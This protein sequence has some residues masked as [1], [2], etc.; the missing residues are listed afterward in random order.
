MADANTA[1]IHDERA[2][3]RSAIAERISRYEDLEKYRLAVVA[4]SAAEV[5][6]CAGGLL[7]DRVMSGWDIT[8]L[9]ADSRD[10]RPLRILGVDVVDLEVAMEWRG[11]QQLCPQGLAVTAD[12]FDSDKRVRA[13][14][15]TTLAVGLTEVIVLGEHCPGPLEHELS[16]A[17]HCLSTAARAFK[18]RALDAAAVTTGEVSRTEHFY[19]NDV[20]RRSP[21]NAYLVRKELS[22]SSM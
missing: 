19:A 4:T 8:V 12:L 20:D 9:V 17:A 7:F 3:V 5:V 21:A 1:R 13:G 2:A 15:L 18:F 6:R 14:V 22:D 10:V 16:N 11:H